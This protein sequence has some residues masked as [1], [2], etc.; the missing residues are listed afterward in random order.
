MKTLLVASLLVAG[1]LASFGWLFQSTL[2]DRAEV[3]DPNASALYSEA[4][5]LR[6]LS[7]VYRK[8]GKEHESSLQ[9]PQLPDLCPGI[10]CRAGQP[11]GK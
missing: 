8:K 5:A 1:S 11:A 3:A 9:H 6:D 10:A 4:K 2:V 7:D